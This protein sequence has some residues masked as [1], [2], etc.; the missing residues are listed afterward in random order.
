MSNAFS[1]VL[2]KLVRNV[3]SVI[4]PEKRFAR[5]LI[6]VCALIDM[7]IEGDAG[8]EKSEIHSTRVNEIS[9]ILFEHK[10]VKETFS[11]S[12]AHNEYLK[13]ISS[14]KSAF[15]M[16]DQDYRIECDRIIAEIAD[17]VKDSAWRADLIKAS[18]L[19][20]GESK[21]SGGDLSAILSKISKSLS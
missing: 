20:A 16:S 8:Q 4:F 6:Q 18:E 19:V 5:A 9:S 14:I 17:N 11:P 13:C 3:P 15:E 7:A 2:E 21:Y 10:T 12:A 1:N